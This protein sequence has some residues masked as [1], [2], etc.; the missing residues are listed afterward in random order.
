MTREG[1][2]GVDTGTVGRSA[3]SAYLLVGLGLIALHLAA[4]GSV[5]IYDAIGLTSCGAVVIGTAIHRPRNWPGWA[6]VGLAQALFAAG[7]FTFHEFPSGFP[8]PPDA[9]YL[10]SYVAFTAGL[11]LLMGRSFPW[12]DFGSHVDTLLVT[13]ALGL[14]C[15]LVFLDHSFELS[16]HP[17]QLVS[18]AYPLADLVALG[19]MIRI[20]LTPGRRGTAYWLLFACLFPLFISDGSYVLP[21]I[22]SSYQL[23][24]WV[25]AGWLGS[26]VLVGAAAL[27][28]SMRTIA[29]TGPATNVGIP[30]RRL[31]LGGAALLIVP[32]SAIIEDATRDGVDV[33]LVAAGGT[34]LLA[35]VVARAAILVRELDRLRARAEESERRFRMMFERAPIGISVGRDGIMSETNPALQ[36]M[37]GYEGNELASM[38]YTEVTHPDD[39]ELSVQRRLDLGECDSFSIEKHYL[40]KDGT[41]VETRVHVVLD[42]ED[43]LGMSLIEDVTDRRRLEAQLREAQKME[44]V[45]KLAGGVAHDFNNLMTAVIGYS[46]LLLR[47]ADQGSK[48]KLEAIRESAVRASDLTR[49]LL[50]FGR[51]QMLQTDELDLRDVVGQSKELLRTLVGDHVALETHIGPEPVLLHADRSQIEQVLLNLADNA[52]AAMPDGG[53]LTVAVTADHGDAVLTVADTGVGMDE[54]TR[55]RIFEPYFTTKP[56]SE[57]SG[58]GLATVHGIVGQSGGSIAV[59]TRPAAGTVFTIRLP[60]GDLALRRELVAPATLV[61]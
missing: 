32:I 56:L 23:G 43:G 34:V 57:A 15:W 16:L 39:R 24:S 28:P 30:L 37:L 12:R 38:H 27:H 55:A 7:D 40:R 29:S 6:A 11:L 58:L 26:Y 61:D 9:F 50:A 51:R 33:T 35:G 8:G 22:G 17:A 52:G 48:E 49:Q 3:A 44:A 60:Q 31:L 42:L 19:L 2:R 53:T 36:R 54:A 46:D 47:K 14:S 1:R 21:A 41:P 59:A 18:I 10:A 4:G 20:A 45:G 5:A 13:V 25:D